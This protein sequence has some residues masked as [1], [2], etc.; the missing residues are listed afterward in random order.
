MEEI[1]VLEE[2]FLLSIS[3]NAPQR[4]RARKDKDAAAAAEETVAGGEGGHA[5]RPGLRQSRGKAA[6]V[7]ASDEGETE[8]GAP[9]L[10]LLTCP[11]A[12]ACGTLAEPTAG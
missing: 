5:G 2:A 10:A 4:R 9:P 11:G 7:S 3:S 1:K 6:V 12:G 8:V